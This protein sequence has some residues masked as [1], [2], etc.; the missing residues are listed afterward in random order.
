MDHQVQ[1]FANESI[2]KGCISLWW[3]F[4]WLISTTSQT[5]IGT[6]FLPTPTCSKL[7]LVGA[8]NKKEHSF[9]IMFNI[10]M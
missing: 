7:T 4:T 10:L 6:V 8:G 1:L 5:G 9:H 2:K 3:T